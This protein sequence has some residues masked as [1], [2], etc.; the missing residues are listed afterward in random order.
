MCLFFVEER[1]ALCEECDTATFLRQTY[2][3]AEAGIEAK[4]EQEGYPIVSGMGKQLWED[5]KES[6]FR[7]L[8]EIE[9][10]KEIIRNFWR[11]R[12][13]KVNTDQ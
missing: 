7:G 12:D 9:N 11:I 1:D 5:S 3:T 8:T 10:I 6:L 2:E 4:R 13:K